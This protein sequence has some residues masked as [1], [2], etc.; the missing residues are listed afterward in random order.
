MSDGIK[1]ANPNP[2]ADGLEGLRR[3]GRDVQENNSLDEGNAD[4]ADGDGEAGRSGRAAAA[5]GTAEP[6]RCAGGGPVGCSSA[7]TC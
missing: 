4:T 7:S 6:V 3:L 2:R 1:P 5:A